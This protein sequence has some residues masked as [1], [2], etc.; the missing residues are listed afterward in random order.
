M[1][2][3]AEIKAHEIVKACSA[4]IDKSNL[5]LKFMNECVRWKMTSEKDLPQMYLPYFKSAQE[6]R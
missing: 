6:A 5:F 4:V 3:S 2:A 1:V